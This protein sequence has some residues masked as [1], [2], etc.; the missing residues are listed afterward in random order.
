MDDVGLDK[1][2]DPVSEVLRL[3]VHIHRHEHLTVGVPVH[4]NVPYLLQFDYR[5]GFAKNRRMS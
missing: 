4:T 3:V 5:I 2:E 1:L